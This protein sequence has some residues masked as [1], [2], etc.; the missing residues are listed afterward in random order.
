MKKINV[1]INKCKGCELC[2]MVCPIKNLK[3]SD[4]MNAY[5]NPYVVVISDD[6]CLAC[7]LC[8]SMCPDWAITIKDKNMESDTNE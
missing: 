8:S 7:C 3:M 6:K 1:D 5:G 4:E 2:I